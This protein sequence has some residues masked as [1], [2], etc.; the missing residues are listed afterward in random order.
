MAEGPARIAG[1][2]DTGQLAP[3]ND[4]DL[5]IFDP[6]ATWTVD[7]G[8]LHH[9]NPITPYDK[10]ELSGQVVSTWL[11]GQQV[12]FKVPRGHFLYSKERASFYFFDHA[13][14]ITQRPLYLLVIKQIH[15]PLRPRIPC[16]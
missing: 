3:G 14:T 1:V 16:S 15:C 5:V 8:S 2:S 13:E 9:R 11:R 10:R 7:A 12:D 4:A 6:E